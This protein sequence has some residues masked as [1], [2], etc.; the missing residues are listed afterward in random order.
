MRFSMIHGTVTGIIDTRVIVITP[1]KKRQRSGSL[2]EAVETPVPD[3]N[4]GRK[5]FNHWFD[6][7]EICSDAI[8]SYA[9]YCLTPHKH[10][11]YVN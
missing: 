7:L 8:I 11:N 9:S 5:A 4:G 6:L 10:Y 3:E 2:K 1:A